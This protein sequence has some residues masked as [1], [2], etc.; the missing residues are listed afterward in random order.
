MSATL[1][2]LLVGAFLLLLMQFGVPARASMVLARCRQALADMRDRAL[3][4]EEKERR[5]QQHALA[6]FAGFLWLTGASLLA[7]ALPAAL[8]WLLGTTGV[9]DFDAIMAETLSWPVLIAAT[10]LGL[11]AFRWRRRP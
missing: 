1:A 5:V 6:M 9:V 3:P 8:L 2:L 11:V 4:D 7:L 10:V